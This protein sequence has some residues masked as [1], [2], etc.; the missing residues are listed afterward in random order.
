[1]DTAG[2]IP[3][4]AIRQDGRAR[5]LVLLAQVNS[6]LQYHLLRVLQLFAR[7]DCAQDGVRAMIALKNRS[8]ILCFII[9][10]YSGFYLAV[11]GI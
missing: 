7:L 5:A 10:P 4:N 1:L 9:W 2:E 3:E 8:F 11:I 6:R